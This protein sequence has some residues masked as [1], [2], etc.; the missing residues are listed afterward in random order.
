MN[1]LNNTL[2][3][4]AGVIGFQAT[5]TISLWYAGKNLF[6]P[7]SPDEGSNLVR[8]VGIDAA[9]KL[10][11]EW[12]GEMIAVPTLWGYEEQARNRAIGSLIGRGLSTKQI[13]VMMGMTERRVQ[14]I[15]RS[16]EDAGLLPLLLP[17]SEFTI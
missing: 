3:D 9:K 1:R 4:I 16:L 17:G 5:L 11:E 12:G 10:A 2:D 15:R 6:V 13:A 8:I 14:Q 7:A